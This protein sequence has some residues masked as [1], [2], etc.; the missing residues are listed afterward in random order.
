MARSM[1]AAKVI[2]TLTVQNKDRKDVNNRLKNRVTA[3]EASVE[4]YADR[5]ERRSVTPEI[6]SLLEKSGHDVRELMA[7]KQRLSVVEVDDMLSKSGVMLEPAMRAALKN[8]L[9]QAGL[10]ENGEVRRWN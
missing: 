3:L 5:V 6:M 4:R 2:R 8:Q 1:A 9:L 10:M 7:S